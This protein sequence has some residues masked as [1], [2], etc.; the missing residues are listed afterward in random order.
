MPCAYLNGHEKKQRAVSVVSFPGCPTDS[1]CCCRRMTNEE[2]ITNGSRM[3]HRTVANCELSKQMTIER[4]QLC[5]I[6]S[7]LL[8]STIRKQ[9]RNVQLLEL[10]ID[11]YRS[12]SF[13]L[14]TPRIIYSCRA[15]LIRERAKR[16][17]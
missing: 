7:Y 17:T 13:F 15:S 10:P 5:G 8:A 12:R 3:D 6:S 4:W 9:L 11:P 1:S 14:L 2:Q 16:G